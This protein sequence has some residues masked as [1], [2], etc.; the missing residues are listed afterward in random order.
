MLENGMA[1]KKRLATENIYVPTLWP[2]LLQSFPSGS[3]ERRL[4]EDI[5]PLPV[6]QRYSAE[7]MRY[8]VSKI[9]TLI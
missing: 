2:E 8:L 5:L 7:D 3:T 4:A 6:D 9:K 1:L